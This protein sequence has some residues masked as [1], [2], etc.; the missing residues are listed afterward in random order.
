MFP[1]EQF[2]HTHRTL[3]VVLSNSL[4]R[5][6]PTCWRFWLARLA[7]PTE[8]RRTSVEYLS[9]EEAGRG[10]VQWALVVG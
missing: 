4:S 7:A 8:A 1:L 9:A 6:A 10:T 5:E 3:F 2:Q